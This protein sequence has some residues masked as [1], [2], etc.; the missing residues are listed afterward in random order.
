ML[1]RSDPTAGVSLVATT[2]QSE[3]VGQPIGGASVRIYPASN[4]KAN[5]RPLSLCRAS[6]T[7]RH[8]SG[9]VL[10]KGAAHGSAVRCCEE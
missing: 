3:V 8:L 2:L 7:P 1:P 4:A 10:P 6:Q 5:F 9:P